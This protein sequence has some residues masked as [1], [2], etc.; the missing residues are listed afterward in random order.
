MLTLRRQV[1]LKDVATVKCM[2]ASGDHHDDVRVSG[3]DSTGT[4]DPDRWRPPR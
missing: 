2:G 4:G 3:G 1:A